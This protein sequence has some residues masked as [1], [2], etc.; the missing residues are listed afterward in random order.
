MPSRRSPRR[1][2]RRSAICRAACCG[3]LGICTVLYVAVAAVMTGLVPSELLA[4]ET[5][6]RARCAPAGLD[7]LATLMSLGAVIAVTAVL[8]VFQLGQPRILF[9]MA[10][11]GLLPPG[12]LVSA[13]A[14]RAGGASRLGQIEACRPD[15]ASFS[16]GSVVEIERRHRRTIASVCSGRAR[17]APARTRHSPPSTS[18]G[19]DEQRAA[20]ALHAEVR[21]EALGAWRSWAGRRCRRRRALEGRGRQRLAAL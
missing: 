2:A 7:R 4:T 17:L 3:R 9:A 20:D 19:F 6:W 11:D 8:I 13:A 16:A 5:R 10:R 21:D 18:T 12:P 15:W 14:A 1:R